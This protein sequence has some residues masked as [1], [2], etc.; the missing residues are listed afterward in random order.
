VFSPATTDPAGEYRLTVPPG[1]YILEFSAPGFSIARKAFV[2]SAGLS[3]QTAVNLEIGHVAEE[4]SVTARKPDI[5]APAP[6]SV[7]SQPVQVGGKVEPCTLIRQVKPAYPED[8]RLAGIEGIVVVHAIISKDGDVLE[9]R[10]VSPDV[11]PRLVEA[12]LGAVRQ[13]KYRPTLLNGHPVETQ[14]DI[15]VA[16]TLQ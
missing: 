4:V 3:T 1:R 13:W 8:L 12:A 11:D 9:P 14:T 7:A 10:S 16:F 15:D 2:A 6:A 5:A